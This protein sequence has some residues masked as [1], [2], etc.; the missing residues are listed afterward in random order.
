MR[1]ISVGGLKEKHRNATPPPAYPIVNS[2]TYL[3]HPTLR[4]KPDLDV[5]A[6]L[7]QI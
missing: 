2:A 6:T 7:L 1:R 5:L 4:E 3:F